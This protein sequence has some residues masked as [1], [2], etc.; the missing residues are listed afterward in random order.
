[1][2]KDFII[3]AGREEVLKPTNGETTSDI[4]ESVNNNRAMANEILSGHHPYKSI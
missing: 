1:M 4:H 3:N 2:F